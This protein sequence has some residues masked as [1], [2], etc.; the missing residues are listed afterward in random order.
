MELP[1]VSKDA[2]KIT[3]QVLKL[4]EPLLHEDHSLWMGGCYNSCAL[5]NFQQS[6]NTDSVG[7]IKIKMKAVMKKLQESR[8]QK[9]KSVTQH[10]GPVCVLRQCDKKH[11]TV[12]SNDDTAEV[13]TLI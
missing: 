7:N 10:S 2:L 11:V 8:L 1:F 5:V 3:A 9:G 13:H 4:C 6:F 12:V